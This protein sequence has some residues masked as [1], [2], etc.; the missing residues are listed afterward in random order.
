MAVHDVDDSQR[1]DWLR[2]ATT[3]TRRDAPR[4]AP[5]AR[6]LVGSV[7]AYLGLD[8]ASF[9][10]VDDVRGTAADS[11]A[12]ESLW[13]QP[14]D[15]PSP[16]LG[17][18][19]Q[20]V[21]RIVAFLGIDVGAVDGVTATEPAEVPIATASTAPAP[22]EDEDEAEPEPEPED[23]DEIAPV[24]PIA[25]TESPIDVDAE[26]TPVVAVS[27]DATRHYWR[28]TDDD[29]LYRPARRSRSPRRAWR[30]RTASRG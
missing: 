22:D 2:D 29:I 3:P 5:R 14:D 17:P 9:G 23:E 6:R 13:R 25:T 4:R 26:E 21:R 24:D 28:R 15:A 16:D 12:P 19:P 7:I 18:R 20:R 8:S 27:D 10:A 1:T 30:D 11:H